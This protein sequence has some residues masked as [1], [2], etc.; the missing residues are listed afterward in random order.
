M[1]G[2]D[3]I[4]PEGE[5]RRLAD[6]YRI[7]FDVLSSAGVLGSRQGRETGASVE[8]QDFRD[9]VP[10]DDPRRIDWFSYG[11]TGSL[12]VRLFRE[13]VSPFFDVIVDA[14]ASMAIDDGRKGPLAHE[15]CRW[16]FHS[17]QTTGLAVR[18][19]SAGSSLVR[20]DSPDQLI[21]D[22]PDCAL[23][24]APG[25]AAAGLRRSSVRLVLSD[26]MSPLGFSTAVASL[27]AGCSRLIVVHLLGPWEADPDPWGPAVLDCVEDGRRADITL[28]RGAVE[29]YARR[30]GALKQEIRELS[31]KHGGLH[32]EVVADR[33]L[34][35]VL[36]LDWMP[37][38]LVE[39]V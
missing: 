8:I 11:R 33:G 35:S 27:A 39:V 29:A 5:I 38:G 13:E 21:F 23:F 14:S 37:L 26:F 4:L 1:S 9:Y 22:A 30:L 17:A 3:E 6:C 31:F 20:L 10:G 16:L 32:L 18:F 36:R 15:L 28:D 7:R 12:I 25:R 24:S 34:E 2:A 19:F